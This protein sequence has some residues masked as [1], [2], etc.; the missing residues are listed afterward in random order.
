MKSLRRSWI[1]EKILKKGNTIQ[2]PFFICKYQD[3]PHKESEICTIVSTKVSKKATLRNRIRRRLRETIRK[4]ISDLNK[5]IQAVIIGKLKA[6]SCT[7]KELE[8]AIITSLQS[9]K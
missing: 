7:F 5:P 8:D 4:H 1:I 9:I 2:T 3:S 6:H